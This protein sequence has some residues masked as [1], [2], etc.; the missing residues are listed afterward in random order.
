MKVFTQ[1]EKPDGS[2]VLFIDELSDGLPIASA[3][4]VSKHFVDRNGVW[5]HNPFVEASATVTQVDHGEMKTPA[6]LSMAEKLGI[7]AVRL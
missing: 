7:T 2:T 1:W 6:I 4:K 3:Q 5:K